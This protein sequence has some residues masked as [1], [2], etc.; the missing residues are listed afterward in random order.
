[1]ELGVITWYH[2]LSEITSLLGKSEKVSREEAPNTH[3]KVPADLVCIPYGTIIPI[4]LSNYP[5]I[6][7]F[8]DN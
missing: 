6:K 4:S 8:S 3:I 7:C 2:G 5:K 1:V